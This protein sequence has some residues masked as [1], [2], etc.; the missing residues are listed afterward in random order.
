MTA[1][2]LEAV[3][4][5]AVTY[6][7]ARI[8]PK[9]LEPLRGLPHLVIVDNASSDGTP[10]VAARI[11][12]QATVLRAPRN[13]GFGRA[14]NLALE[15]VTTP[16]ALLL[17]PDCV[18]QPEAIER[19][20]AAAHRYPEAA[21]LAP[22]LYDAPGKLGLCYRPGAFAPQPRELLDPAGDLC[23][24]FL[25]GAAMLLRMDAMR[26]VGF[27]DPWFFLYLEDDDLCL[28]TRRAGHALVLV[29]EATVLHGVRQS[30]APSAA[31]DFRR[32]YCLTLSKLYLAKKHLGGGRALAE[33]LRILAAAALTLPL[34]ALTLNRRLLIR[35]WA[36]LLAALRAPARLAAPHCLPD[37]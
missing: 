13:L 9:M 11:A 33:G 18:I 37:A 35:S 3:T 2:P 19:L 21:I 27:F 29:N 14:N 20:V 1:P 7:S 15:R 16:F 26:R 25:T 36:R 6:N 23:S 8:L 5:V 17:N 24:E 28:R 31:L 12:P 22:K 34:Y 4:V 10:E 30:S 32:A